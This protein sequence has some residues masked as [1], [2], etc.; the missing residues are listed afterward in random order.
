MQLDLSS[1]VPFV[2]GPKRPH[3]LVEVSQLPADFKAC[4]SA[5]AG[6]KGFGVADDNHATKA[7]FTFE[8]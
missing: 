5:P 4:M 6:F 1:L 8:G 2:S 3:D 7:K